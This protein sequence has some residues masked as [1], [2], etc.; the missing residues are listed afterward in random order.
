MADRLTAEQRHMCMSRIRGKDT[1]PEMVVRKALFAAGFR[2]RVNAA[3]LPGR[4]DVV[5]RKYNT[6]IFVNGCFW[7]GHRGCRLYSLPKSNTGFWSL[8]IERNRRRDAA[9]NA[10]LEARGWHVVTVWE[11]ELSPTRRKGTIEALMQRIRENKVLY[12][13]E[14]QRRRNSSAI[15]RSESERAELRRKALESEIDSIYRVPSGIRKISRK[16]ED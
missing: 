9:V 5:L 15:L 14:M 13:N 2:F 7:H 10:R 3:Y 11:C 4:P 8:K 1:G 6:V 16:E 12:D